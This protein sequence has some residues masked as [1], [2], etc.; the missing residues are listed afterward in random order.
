VTVNQD[1]YRRRIEEETS[2]AERERNPDVRHVH[3]TL[4]NLYRIR[5]D[6]E[7][8]RAGDPTYYLR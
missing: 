3:E 7:K 2:R 6:G 8:P 4:A 5:L 1:Y